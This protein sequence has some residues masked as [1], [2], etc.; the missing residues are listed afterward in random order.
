MHGLRKAALALHVPKQLVVTPGRQ[1]VY[2]ASGWGPLDSSILVA[3]CQRGMHGT[4]PPGSL[5]TKRHLLL[6]C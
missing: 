6:S 5:L 4:G 2:W 3:L 1:D